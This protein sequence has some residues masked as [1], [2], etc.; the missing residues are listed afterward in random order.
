MCTAAT[1]T[2][3]NER[4]VDP[5]LKALPQPV[6]ISTKSGNSAG[7]VSTSSIVLTHRIQ[8]SEASV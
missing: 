8:F 1:P 6:S 7:S 3:M 5:I 2:L 4:I